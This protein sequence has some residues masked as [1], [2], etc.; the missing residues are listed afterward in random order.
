MVSALRP[1]VIEY[2]HNLNT[3]SLGSKIARIDM[4]ELWGR[5]SNIAIG[6]CHAGI[7]AA[8]DNFVYLSYH[9]ISRGFVGLYRFTDTIDFVRLR[10]LDWSKIVYRGAPLASRTSCVDE[11]CSAESALAGYRA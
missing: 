8:E 1:Y 3:S 10:K 5:A 7:L 9:N 6:Q 11:L 4:A 2:H